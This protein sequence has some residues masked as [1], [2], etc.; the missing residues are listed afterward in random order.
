M[1]YEIQIEREINL[2]ERTKDRERER[3]R[4]G[5]CGEDNSGGKKI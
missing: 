2:E 3:K 1:G 5:F 4:E